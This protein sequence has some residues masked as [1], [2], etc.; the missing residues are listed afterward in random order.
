L[1]G[2][3]FAADRTVAD[4]FAND[5][6]HKQ[7]DR[8]S[9]KK[10]DKGVV[11]KTRKPSRSQLQVVPQKRYK[12]GTLQGDEGSVGSFV[13]GHV[14][15]H[16]PD[17][18]KTWVKR[19]RHVDDKT[20]DD[21]HAHLSAGKAPHDQKRFGVAAAKKNTFRSYMHN[22]DSSLTQ[23]TDD[24]RQQVRDKFVDHMRKK[25]KHG[26]V[27][28]NT[29]PTETDKVRSK[30]SYILFHPEKHSLSKE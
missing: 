28:T 14:F 11:F 20:A 27:Y 5:V 2:A 1:V 6:Y 3:H 15:K 23:A 22:F 9:E 17:M 30:K 8:F 25:G 21:I 12:S 24:F 18:F 10:P 13:S 4:K 29:S 19:A 26:L 16:H 7:S